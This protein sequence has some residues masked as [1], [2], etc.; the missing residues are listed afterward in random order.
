VHE[1]V[2]FFK[3]VARVSSLQEL[4]MPQWETVVGEEA[5]DC[6]EALCAMPQLRVVYVTT[7]KDSPVF[8]PGLTF[9][10]LTS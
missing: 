5:A 8:P 9:L 4:V 6:V 7:V 3:A 10:P 1:K 2:L